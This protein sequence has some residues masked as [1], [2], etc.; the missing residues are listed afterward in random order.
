M[1]VSQLT[2]NK[3]K[4]YYLLLVLISIKTEVK[5]LA[6]ITLTSTFFGQNLSQFDKKER[7]NGGTASLSLIREFGAAERTE[8][9][10]LQPP[11]P[12]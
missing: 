3:R 10:S 6:G 4:W 7:E 12:S 1:P 8:R 9:T 5:G 11:A 2:S